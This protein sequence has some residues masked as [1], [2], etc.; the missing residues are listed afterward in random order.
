MC[1]GGVGGD[2]QARGVVGSGGGADD[3]LL[4][5]LHP[6]F[7]YTDLADDPRTDSGVGPAVLDLVDDVLG[8]SAGCPLVDELGVIG[9]PVEAGAHHDVHAGGLRDAVHRL[10]LAAYVFQDAV[11]EGAAARIPVETDLLGHLDFVGHRHRHP[12]MACPRYV[13]EYVI[14]CLGMAQII[15]RDGSSHGHYL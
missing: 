10:R 1:G 11:D 6:A 2:R 14:V 4:D 8:Q 5:A 9:L 13:G 15:G 12:A 3:P 7:V